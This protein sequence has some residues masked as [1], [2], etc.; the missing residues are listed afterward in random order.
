MKNSFFKVFIVFALISTF[1]YAQEVENVSEK[2]T[3]KQI[4][5]FGLG[6]SISGE[7]EFSA[8]GISGKTDTDLNFPLMLEVEY[9]NTG[10]SFLLIGYNN[11]L[12]VEESDFAG[13]KFKFKST[14][15]GYKE[16]FKTKLKNN[17]QEEKQYFVI[18]YG[19]NTDFSGNTEYAVDSTTIS[20][21]FD[22][23]SYLALGWG[24]KSDKKT[25]YEVLYEISKGDFIE[26]NTLLGLY[27][28]EVKYTRLS[29]YYYFSF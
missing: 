8:F 18:K 26:N 23:D 15:V 11:T 29:A 19:L 4:I 7:E 5:N 1:C 16:Y 6:L 9:N 14:Y 28:A 22:G 17:N 25:G 2:E 12:D 13:S 3:E 24:T 10:N 20:Y 27:T 21:A